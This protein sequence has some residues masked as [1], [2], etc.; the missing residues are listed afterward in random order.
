MLTQGNFDG[1]VEF[2]QVLSGKPNFPGRADYDRC[3][4]RIPIKGQ[5]FPTSPID[6]PIPRNLDQMISVAETLGRGLDYIRV[7]MYNLDGRIVFGEFTHYPTAGLFPFDPPEIDVLYG[8][9]WR[10]PPSYA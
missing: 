4:N 5:Q 9:K 2:L 3:L 10:V 7:D 1:H 8:S 6:P